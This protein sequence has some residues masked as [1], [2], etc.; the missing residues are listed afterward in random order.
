M[1]DQPEPDTRTVHGGSQLACRRTVDTITDAE[2]NAL[3]DTI[4]RL[5]A[6]A[7]HAESTV[8]TFC[9]AVKDWDVSDRGTYIPHA[10]LVAIGR[11]AGTDVLGSIRHLRH[12]E[13]V[14]QAEAAVD[15][16]Q[17]YAARLDQF[18]A[19]TISVPDSDL[20]TAIANDLRTA[21]APKESS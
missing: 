8:N 11:A 21:L 14:E 2:L 20:Y 18:A 7:Q 5:N 12:F 10:S 13:R 9:R 16:V 17:A 19:T 1:T 6:R 4:Q 3:Y 15:R